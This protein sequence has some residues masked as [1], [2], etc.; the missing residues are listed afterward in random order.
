MLL[1]CSCCSIRIISI[2]PFVE[3]HAGVVLAAR[4]PH[5]EMRARHSTNS[6]YLPTRDKYRE[7]E[8]TSIL[9]TATANTATTANSANSAIAYL[10][11]YYQV[12]V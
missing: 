11:V 10:I 3:L 1:F 8:G 9:T 7:E 4:E 12:V 6:C 5:R 2:F